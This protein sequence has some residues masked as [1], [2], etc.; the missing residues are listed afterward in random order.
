[1]NKKPLVS[2]IIPTYNRAD[3]LIEA[4][5]SVLRQSYA[6]YEIIV[7]DDGSTDDTMERI[8]SM[9]GPIRYMRL[10]HTGFPGK[11]R[12]QGIKKSRGSL[13]AFLDSD[14]LWAKDKLAKQVD[15]FLEDEDLGLVYSN[16]RAYSGDTSISEPILKLH[17]LRSDSVFIELLKGCFIHPSTVVVQR[18]LFEHLGLFDLRFESQEYYHYWLRSA[19][20]YQIRAVSE[21]LVYVRRRPGSLSHR[22][23]ARDWQNAISVFEHLLANESLSFRQRLIARRTLSRFCTHVGLDYL[24]S[25]EESIAD[26]YLWRSIFWNPIQRRAWLALLQREVSTRGYE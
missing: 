22:L 18:R 19:L 10:R 23:G 25:G 26:S 4:I 3:F 11:A 5:Q 12:N 7:A 15:L 14:D 8:A 1:M 16:V 6:H 21:A 17:Q 2:V 20:Y 24:N 9:D 13:V